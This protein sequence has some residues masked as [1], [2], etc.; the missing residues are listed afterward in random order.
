MSVFYFNGKTAVSQEAQARIETDSLSISVNGVPRAEWP[1]ADIRSQSKAGA[2]D[3][4]LLSSIR[5][6][7]ARLHVTDSALVAAVR[8]ACPNLHARPALANPLRYV[9]WLAAASVAVAVSATVLL[10]YLSRSLAG[11]MSA[12]AERRIADLPY[13]KWI[14]NISARQEAPM[15]FCSTPKGD[16]ALDKV[17]VRV[18]GNFELPFELDVKVTDN[19]STNAVA[20][21]A[22]RILVYQ[23]LFDA[24]ETPAQFAAIMAHEVGHV[25]AKHMTAIALRNAASTGIGDLL[26]ATFPGGQVVA[27]FTSNLQASS[28]GRQSEREADAF[29]HEILTEAGISPINL[30]E[31]F[32]LMQSMTLEQSGILTYLHTH[33]AHDGRIEAAL[34]ASESKEFSDDPILT[35]DE[36][37]ALTSICAE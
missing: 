1:L 30:A 11:I 20:F 27:D 16:A 6:D 3:A 33:P 13:D 24:T 9:G 10:P 35:E 2:K 23:G 22:G 19:R 8:R 7:A 28:F 36:W 15:R 31:A 17:F 32:T 12:E 26:L 18:F 25:Y 5:D 29:A 21:P 4:L 37:A 34:A 14:A